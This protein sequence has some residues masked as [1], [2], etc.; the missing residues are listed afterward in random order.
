M[1][2]TGHGGRAP[3]TSGAK[4]DRQHHAA[5]HPGNS[6]HWKEFQPNQGGVGCQGRASGPDHSAGQDKMA[7]V[8]DPTDDNIAWEALVSVCSMRHKETI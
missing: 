5:A 6:K 4:S 8:S 3:N 1:G 2:A 7:G